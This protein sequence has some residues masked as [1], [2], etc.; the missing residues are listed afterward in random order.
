[1]TK[2]SFF[3]CCC[4]LLIVVICMCF[5][6]DVSDVIKT[7]STLSKL[8]PLHKEFNQEDL[9][10]QCYD[11][12]ITTYGGDSDTSEVCMVSLEFVTY[13]VNREGLSQTHWDKVNHSSLA[14]LLDNI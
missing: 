3:C 12:L 9:T 14:V 8:I 11:K 4:C 13:V 7:R 6:C 10:V 2:A 1:M 5:L